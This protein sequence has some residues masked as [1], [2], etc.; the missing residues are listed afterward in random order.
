MYAFEYSFHPI[1]THNEGFGCINVGHRLITESN[2][3]I[4][5]KYDA[6][7]QAGRGDT[8]TFPLK[9]VVPKIGMLAYFSD[10]LRQEELPL[11]HPV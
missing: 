4:V 3:V 11:S 1:I 2:C 7:L 8:Y 10:C 6:L 9:N 5:L